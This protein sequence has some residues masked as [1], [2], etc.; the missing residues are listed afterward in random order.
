M[1]DRPLI[2]QDYDYK[3]GIH[4]SKVES[5]LDT[6]YCLLFYYSVADLNLRKCKHCERW[7]AVKNYDDK[8]CNRLSLYEGYENKNCKS[9]VKAIKDKI[10]ARRKGEYERLRQRANEYGVNSV[11]Y[12][13]LTTFVN[14]CNDYKALIKK[15]PTVSILKEYERFVYDSEGLRPKY[16][17]IKNW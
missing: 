7:F 10:E 6:L 4:F 11:H 8:M 15:N 9:A 3:N 5:V 17:R 13:T 12:E 1:L 16:E 2:Y 14:K